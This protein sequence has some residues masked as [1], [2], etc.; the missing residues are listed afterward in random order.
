VWLGKF[1]T[2]RVFRAGVPYKQKLNHIAVAVTG[3]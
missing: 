2:L 1:T 3:N